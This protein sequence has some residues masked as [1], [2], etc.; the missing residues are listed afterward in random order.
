MPTRG[1]TFNDANRRINALTWFPHLGISQL[2]ISQPNNDPTAY[3]ASDY[4]VHTPL[5]NMLHE[6][7]VLTLPAAPRTKLTGE[8][9]GQK[10]TLQPMVLHVK[11]TL[12]TQQAAALVPAACP[13]SVQSTSNSTRTRE[14]CMTTC[15]GTS[16][17][18][19]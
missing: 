13:T 17:A 5:I 18:I 15:Y 4:T 8:Y 10:P 2:G 19:L 16:I 3:K 7:T 1:V 6:L 14:K 12:Q 11:R 9:V